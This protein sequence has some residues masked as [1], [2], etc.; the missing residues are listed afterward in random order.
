MRLDTLALVTF[1]LA[2]CSD[3]GSLQVG[4]GPDDPTDTPSVTD[5]PTD[6]VT[7]DTDV[8]PAADRFDGVY[9][10][11]FQ[12]E[13]TSGWYQTSCQGQAKVVVDHAAT[14][15]VKG[16]GRCTLNQLQITVDT[17]IE[18][19]VDGAPALA[20]RARSDVAGDTVED[21]WSG[22]LIAPG[23]VE[24][25]STGTYDAGWVQFDYVLRLRAER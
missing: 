23:T 10:G 2:G 17:T 11:V 12:V 16:E 18:A 19:S 8:E 5:A 1:L 20:G 7:D 24:G 13:T 22:E 4:P 25:Q 9:D 15:Q 6:A 21:D 3:R 14:P